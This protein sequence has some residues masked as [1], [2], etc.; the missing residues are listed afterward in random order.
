MLVH[1]LLGHLRDLW[2]AVA[3]WSRALAPGGVMLMD[4]VESI[5]TT[6]AALQ[7]YLGLAEH[8]VA[9]RGAWHKQ[10]RPIVAGCGSLREDFAALDTMAQGSESIA[11]RSPI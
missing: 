3:G 6:K 11:R 8:V 7:D 9:H 1:P 2:A 4:E 10:P 5:E